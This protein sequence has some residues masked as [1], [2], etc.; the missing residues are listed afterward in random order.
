MATN[1]VMFS[2]FLTRRSDV[3]T[4]SKGS[5]GRGSGQ[6]D[7]RSSKKGGRSSKKGEHGITISYLLTLS[8]HHLS[9]GRRSNSVDML[10]IQA[11]NDLPEG[12]GPRDVKMGGISDEDKEPG[13]LSIYI[14]LS[15]SIAL[16]VSL[17]VAHPPS[18]ISW[19]Q[20]SFN[21]IQ[22]PM[23]QARIFNTISLY[24]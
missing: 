5:K 16:M 11:P 19:I 1:V 17:K 9:E 20:I 21:L 22:M 14:Y 23:H 24:I 15:F 10:D 13:K 6:V 8:I 2:Y 18:Q 4:L 7:V 3:H 12:G